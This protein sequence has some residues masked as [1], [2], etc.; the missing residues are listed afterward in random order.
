MTDRSM[1]EAPKRA[2]GPGR[3][4]YAAGALALTEPGPAAAG[5]V[6][7]DER[8]RLISQRSHYLGQTTRAGA[9]AEA[10]LA[11]ARFAL[12]SNLEEPTFHVDDQAL[13][14]ALRGGPSPDEPAIMAPLRDVLAQIPGHIIAPVSPAHNLARAVALAPLV[15]WLPERTRRSEGLAV[16]SLGDCVYEVTSESQPEQVYRVTLRPPGVDGQDDPISCQCGDFVHRGIP[17]KHL[18]AVARELGMIDQVFH[19]R[20]LAGAGT[21]TAMSPGGEARGD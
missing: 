20:P 12:Q 11:A 21:A 2:A 14:G 8:G 18:L 16:R 7:A 4:V 1:R 6:V 10:L 3:H 17:C 15:E 5:I 9:T 13:V 19:V